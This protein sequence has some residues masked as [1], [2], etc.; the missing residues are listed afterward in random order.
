M[1]LTF[2]FIGI[3]GGGASPGPIEMKRF[4][5]FA[6]TSSCIMTTVATKKSVSSLN[7][8][9]GMTIA[10]TTSANGEVS[11]GVEG[12]VA[13]RN[14]GIRVVVFSAATGA[15][16]VVTVW[17]KTMEHNAD[18]GCCHPILKNGTVLEIE[19]ARPTFHCAESDS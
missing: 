10:F 17:M 5:F 13:D 12:V 18:I 19:C 2:A 6:I 14:S 15:L 11:S 8:P 4:A 3:F 16:I 9:R 1:K 7:T